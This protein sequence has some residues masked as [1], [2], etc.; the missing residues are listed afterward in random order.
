MTKYKEFVEEYNIS[1]KFSNNKNFISYHITSIPILNMYSYENLNLNS[2]NNI[3][4]TKEPTERNEIMSTNLPT[5][6]H[7]NLPTNLHTN[8]PTNLHTN[9]PTNCPTVK[10][11]TTIFPTNYINKNNNNNDNKNNNKVFIISFTT[12]FISLCLFI[13]YFYKYYLKYKKNKKQL[14][15]DKLDLEFGITYIEDI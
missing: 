6:L 9:L 3:Y 13:A 11:L 4:Y 2:I 15:Q 14:K 8:L 7:T 10:N 5:N 1:N 12:I